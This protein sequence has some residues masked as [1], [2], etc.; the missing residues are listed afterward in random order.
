M[1]RREGEHK[2]AVENV[3]INHLAACGPVCT[4]MTAEQAVITATSMPMVNLT[5]C[6]FIK[7]HFLLLGPHQ[8]RYLTDSTKGLN[9]NMHQALNRQWCAA[10]AK[11]PHEHIDSDVSGYDL[12]L[13]PGFWMA[14]HSACN[15]VGL[16]LGAGL[17]VSA[18]STIGP[19]ISCC[20]FGL[21]LTHTAHRAAI[22]K[23]CYILSLP[24]GS[25]AVSCFQR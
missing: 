20:C 13:F 1:K 11:H 16:D 24:Y 2:S 17:D 14:E 3:R 22:L 9:T 8:G 10:S 19:S 6:K 23:D 5:Q 15:T 25:K 21:V 7:I 12:L 4:H 18:F